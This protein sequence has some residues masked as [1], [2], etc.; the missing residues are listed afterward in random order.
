MLMEDTAAGDK[1]RRPCCEGRRRLIGVSR[2]SVGT[3]PCHSM[4][5]CLTFAETS[6]LDGRDIIDCDVMLIKRCSPK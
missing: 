3:V 1:P 2:F 4:K 6:R 5:E